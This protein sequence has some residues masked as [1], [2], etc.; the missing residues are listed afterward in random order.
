MFKKGKLGL[1]KNLEV[2]LNG[3]T[4]FCQFIMVSLFSIIFLV[5]LCTLMP[6]PQVWGPFLMAKCMP[7]LSLTVGK[8]LARNIAYT[9]MI[10][11]LVALKVWH[12]QWAGL[13]VRIQCDNQ[14]VVSISVKYW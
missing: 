7:F 11:I 12:I 13:K 9:E 14:A 10:N 2:T 4:T 8:M 6:V 3:S 5:N 1:L